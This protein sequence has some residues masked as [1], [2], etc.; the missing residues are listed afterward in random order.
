[1][2]NNNKIFYFILFY[3]IHLGIKPGGKNASLF[4]ACKW[5]EML[6][7]EITGQKNPIVMMR[8]QGSVSFVWKQTQQ[9]G[10]QCQN[11]LTGYWKDWNVQWV[12]SLPA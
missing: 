11:C 5:T 4:L 12:D 8:Q 3:S 1:M 9:P 10:L 7:V 2:Y 6:S